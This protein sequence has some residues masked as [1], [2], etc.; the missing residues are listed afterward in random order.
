LSQVVALEAGEKPQAAA[1]LSIILSKGSLD[2][3]YPAFIL[4]NT[5]AAMGMEVHVF[6]TFWGMDVISKKRVDSLK[7]SSVGNPALPMPNLMGVLPGMTA[8]VTR[9]LGKKMKKA[10]IPTIHELIKT[11]KENGVKLHACSTTMDVMGISREGFIAEV[12]DVV[13]AATFLQMSE[14]GQTIFI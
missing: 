6:F 3:A 5:A 11:A 10:K 8:L 4:A 1:K 2:M 13:G 9:M 7:V 14:G 12:D